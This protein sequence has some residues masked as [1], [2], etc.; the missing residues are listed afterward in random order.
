MI[1]VSSYAWFVPSYAMNIACT[2][3]LLCF[4]FWTVSFHFCAVVE[5]F[6]VAYWSQYFFT[7]IWVVTEIFLVAYG[8]QLCF[9]LV[10]HELQLTIFNCIWVAV[11]NFFCCIWVATKQKFTRLLDCV[12]ICVSRKVAYMLQLK[13]SWLH[14]FVGI[15]IFPVAYGLQLRKNIAVRWRVAHVSQLSF[16][17]RL[18]P[19]V[20]KL[21]WSQLNKKWPNCFIASWFEFV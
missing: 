1:H 3:R 11:E 5:I 14:E 12:D 17:H 13:F 21:H 18:Q 15:E 10:T 6:R 19:R 2:R 9:F 20:L 16:T 4:S 8:L 7:H